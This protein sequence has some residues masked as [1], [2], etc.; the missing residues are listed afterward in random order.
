MVVGSNPGRSVGIASSRVCL[1]GC[2]GSGHQADCEDDSMD[3]GRL[4]HLGVLDQ[5]PTVRGSCPL[6]VGGN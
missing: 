3:H 6:L 1:R 4:I 5:N 2:D